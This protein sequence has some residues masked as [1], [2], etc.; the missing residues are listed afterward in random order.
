M[1]PALDQ[2]GRVALLPFGNPKAKVPAVKRRGYSEVTMSERFD[3]GG[4]RLPIKLD[5]TSNGEF[6]PQPVAAG[7]RYANR[8]AREKARALGV[9]VICIHKGIP[10]FNL[11]Y[12]YSTCRDIGIVARRYPDVTFIVYHSGFDPG[13]REGPYD[14]KNVA[15]GVD[16]LVKSL[17]DNGI[18]P[19]SNVHAELGTTWRQLLQDPDQAAPVLGKLFRYVGENNVLWGTDFATWGPRD[20]D[21][22]LALHAL[23]QGKV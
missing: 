21:E 17:E 3:P 16:S 6:L 12:E 11:D 14:P 19:N 1:N 4:R 22:F 5:A 2:K 20:A 10:L 8:L 18:P 13:R 23:S 15:G 9:K 7:V